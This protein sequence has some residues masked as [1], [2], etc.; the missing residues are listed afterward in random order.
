VTA[1]LSYSRTVVVHLATVRDS[2]A[3]FF[4]LMSF[5][6]EH[7]STIA[8]LTLEIYD[9]FPGIPNPVQASPTRNPSSR[10]ITTDRALSTFVTVAPQGQCPVDF[11]AS[12]NTSYFVRGNRSKVLNVTLY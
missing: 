1:L 4:K 8:G 7:T 11:S 9:R 3:I 12:G 5:E 2:A 6:M 10:G